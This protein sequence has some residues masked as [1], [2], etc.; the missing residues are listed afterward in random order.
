MQYCAYCKCC[1]VC[2]QTALECLYY[3]EKRKE[4]DLVHDDVEKNLMKVRLD[5]LVYFSNCE[6][7]QNPAKCLSGQKH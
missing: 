7:N 4:I 3:R 5:L 6:N 1:L 2:L